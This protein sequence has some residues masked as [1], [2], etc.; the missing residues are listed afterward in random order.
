M[1][2]GSSA[3][4][5]LAVFEAKTEEFSAGP[6]SLTTVRQAGTH[7]RTA[8]EDK[9]L[10]ESTPTA[11]V[12]ISPRDTLAKDAAPHANEIY[13]LSHD[14][15]VQLFNIAALAFE[16]LR[17]AAPNSGSH[18][19]REK[20]IDIYKKHGV[21]MSDIRHLLTSFSTRFATGRKV[22]TTAA[23]PLHTQKEMIA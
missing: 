12:I 7:E 3:H 19:L 4:G 9:T 13:H 1:A 8:K 16:E 2:A 15:I 18:E 11:I 23:K 14:A 22:S 10:P 20:A 21:Y 5:S 17:L 6:I